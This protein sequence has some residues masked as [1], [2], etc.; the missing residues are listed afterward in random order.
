MNIVSSIARNRFA[1]KGPFQT[2]ILAD[3]RSKNVRLRTQLDM[4]AQVVPIKTVAGLNTRYQNV[5]IDLIVVRENTQGEYS[6]FEQT[7][8]PG[9][10]QSLKV[11]TESASYRVARFAFEL[12]RREK[13]H[14]VTAIHKANIQKATD[15]L[16]LDVCREVASEFQDIEYGEMIIDNTCMQM[17]MNPSQFDV[18]LAPNLYGNIITNVGCGLVGGPGLCPGLNV[19]KTVSV[20]EAGARHVAADI[21]GM[22]V[23]NPTAMILSSAMMLSHLGHPDIGKKVEKAVYKTIADGDCLTPDMGGSA[24]TREF[25]QA[26]IENLGA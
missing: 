16:F 21:A 17:V 3:S 19:G 24:H 1:I 25:T 26:I 6:G 18:M 22:D 20:F 15:G 11:I 8:E 4:F 13:R 2:D 14:K 10:V 9:V 7:V 12:A 23:A 5:P